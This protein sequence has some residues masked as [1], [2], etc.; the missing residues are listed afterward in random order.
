MTLLLQTARLRSQ[1]VEPISTTAVFAFVITI[2]HSQDG[3]PTSVSS[4]L[5]GAR[6]GDNRMEETP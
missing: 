3:I 2:R 5:T 6:T 1:S 4:F